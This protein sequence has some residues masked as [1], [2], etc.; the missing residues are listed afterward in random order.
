[1]SRLKGISRNHLLAQIAGFRVGDRD[2]WKRSDDLADAFTYG[3]LVAFT[4]E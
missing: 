4:G 2:A 1:M 3:V